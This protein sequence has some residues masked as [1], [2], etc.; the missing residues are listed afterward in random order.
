MHTTSLLVNIWGA[1]GATAGAKAAAETVVTSD[2]II[3]FSR[4]R[5]PQP[6]G[7]TTRS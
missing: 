3:R 1:I 4:N 7:T 2:V 6:S 5:P